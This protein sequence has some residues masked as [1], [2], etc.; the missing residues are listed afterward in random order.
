[1]S[2][3]QQQIEARLGETV[4]ADQLTS[5]ESEALMWAV[6]LAPNK[7]GE[8]I[9][10]ESLPGDVQVCLIA[11]I[12]RKLGN[13]NGIKQET[14][15]EYSY[16]LASPQGASGV[17]LFTDAEATII[18]RVAGMRSTANMSVPLC[19]PAVLDLD[20]PEVAR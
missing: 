5:W 10:Y 18:R 17:S 15:G 6:H 3:L 2:T 9:S 19:V 16:T 11:A 12:S 4:D 13:P 20:A 1:M 8:W 7:R 14:I